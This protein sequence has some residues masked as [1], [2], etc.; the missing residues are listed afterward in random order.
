MGILSFVAIVYCIT[1]VLW[2]IFA[3]LRKEER[4]FNRISGFRYLLTFFINMLF[5]PICMFIAI[6]TFDNNL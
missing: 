2:G 5:M 1:T 6:I 4:Y 3:V